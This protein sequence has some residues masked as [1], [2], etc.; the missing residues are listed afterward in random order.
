MRN[1]YVINLFINKSGTTSRRNFTVESGVYSE[2]IFR[3]LITEKIKL[4]TDKWEIEKEKI[5][6][7]GGENLVIWEVFLKK[8]TN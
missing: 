8:V 1:R 3:N 6:P 5:E 2:E 7:I 4:D